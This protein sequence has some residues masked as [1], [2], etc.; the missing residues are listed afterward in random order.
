[1]ELILRDFYYLGRCLEGFFFGMMSV[2]CQTQITKAV[3]H[4]PIPGLYS[5]IFAMYLQHYR[6]QQSTNRAKNILFYAL[7]V[8]YALSATIIIVDILELCWID[9]VGM[10]DHRFLTFLN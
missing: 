6:S 4:C 7:C 2:N 3:Q 8:L 1:M 9:A 10:N 5:G